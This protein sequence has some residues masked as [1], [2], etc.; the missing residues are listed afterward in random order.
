VIPITEA[1]GDLSRPGFGFEL[2]RADASRYAAWTS[3]TAPQTMILAN[4][5]SCREQIQQLTGRRPRHFAEAVWQ[6]L[7]GQHG[8]SAA[9]RT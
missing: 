6:H 2:T 8:D 9:A 1:A 3:Q 7:E 4:G 5:F